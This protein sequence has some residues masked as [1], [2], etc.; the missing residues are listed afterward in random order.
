MNKN[1]QN[2]TKIS[3]DSLSSQNNTELIKE[4]PIG[5][6]S[7]PIRGIQDSEEQKIKNLYKA[8]N[9]CNEV[10]ERLSKTSKK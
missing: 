10:Y 7:I 2:F 9:D 6:A 3:W 4:L 5:S 1:I 8:I